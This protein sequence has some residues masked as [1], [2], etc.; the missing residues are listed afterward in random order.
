MWQITVSPVKK[1]LAV[2]VRATQSDGG[3]YISNE[4]FVTFV[5]KVKTFQLKRMM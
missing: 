3:F 2:C 4:V 5:I 1:P